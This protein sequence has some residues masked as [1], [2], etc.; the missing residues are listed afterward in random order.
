VATRRAQ[1]ADV[2]SIAELYAAHSATDHPDRPDRPDGYLYQHLSQEA[3]TQRA[4]CQTPAVAPVGE[5][6]PERR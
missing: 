3:R 4:L 5:L 1:P 2:A 6:P